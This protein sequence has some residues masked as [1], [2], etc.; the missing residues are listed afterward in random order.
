VATGTA[1]DRQAIFDQHPDLADALRAFFADYDRVH[2]LA[3][4]LHAVAQAARGETA[5]APAAAS[6]PG[7]TL[8]GSQAAAAPE[9]QG[10]DPTTAL[11]TNHPPANGGGDGDLSRGAR[12]RYFGD[13]E[14]SRVLGRGGMGVV[15]KARQ[16]SLNR[17]VALKM[18]RAGLWAGEEEVRRFRNEAEAVA[19]LDHPQ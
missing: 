10:P 17:P 1:P 19:N 15:Y 12:V 11:S 4:P 18:I 8:V 7:A 14:L 6:E 5:T 3:Q 16:V 13:Y 9:G 2:R